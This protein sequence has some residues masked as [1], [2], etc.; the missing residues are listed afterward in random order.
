MADHANNGNEGGDGDRGIF[1]Y[2]GGEQ[3]VPEDV[4][5]VRIDKSVEVIE[6]NAFNGCWDLEQ[7][8]THDGIRKVGMSAFHKCVSLRS[9]VLRSAVEIDDMAFLGC[10]NLT[11]VKFGD[12]LETIGKWAFDECT[13]LVHL[14][15]PFII[16]VKSGAFKYCKALTSIELSVRLETIEL[17]AFY[18]CE[19]LRHIAIP[20][21]RDLFLFDPRR[22]KYTQFGD[23]DLLTTVD[24]VGG[25]HNKT[26]SSLHMESWR[27]EM[28]EEIN[29]INQVLPNIDRQRK[30]AAIKEW[31][32][33]VIDKMG[34]YKAEHHR[35]V[36]EAV[37]LLELALWKAKLDEKDE[38]GAAG[39]SKKV[40]LDAESAR[41]EKRVTCGADTVI[42]NVLP[43]LKL[44]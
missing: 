1:I 11:D 35:Y 30:T 36:K 22:H 5:H 43:F 34:H 27:T 15:L 31:M 2:M 6:D 24:L 16:T 38:N 32:V 33:S 40:K 10:E 4:T 18:G 29:R 17:N 25:T 14:K 41:K 9:I 21:K 23:C 39:R 26:L 3:V 12:K 28:I 37:T 8:D 44:E 20:L 13:S 7:V 42:R 19:R